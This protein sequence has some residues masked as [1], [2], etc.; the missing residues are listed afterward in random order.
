MLPFD[1]GLHRLFDLLCTLIL[2]RQSLGG[3]RKNQKQEDWEQ[4][5]SQLVHRKKLNG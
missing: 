5:I 2:G 4:K 3:P 1:T